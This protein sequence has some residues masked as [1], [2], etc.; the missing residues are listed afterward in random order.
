MVFVN[1]EGKW[2]NGPAITELK[3]RYKNIVA[4][5]YP[6]MYTGAST[7]GFGDYSPGDTCGLTDQIARLWLDKVSG[8]EPPQ[9]A[10][11]QI[12]PKNI[13]LTYYEDKI[14]SP[15]KVQPISSK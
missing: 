15:S 3:I 7:T 11:L 12:G 5:F 14:F 6:T 8:I 4:G 1:S 10:D 9:Q 2:K 13:I